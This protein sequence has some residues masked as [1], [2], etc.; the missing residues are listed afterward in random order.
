MDCG[1]VNTG[2]HD[3][4]TEDGSETR[5]KNEPR[6]GSRMPGLRGKR[7]AA[8]RRIGNAGP[9]KGTRAGGP[10]W[11]YAGPLHQHEQDCVVG[12]GGD[13]ADQGISG[14]GQTQT[15]RRSRTLLMI[16]LREREAGPDTSNRVALWLNANR[17]FPCSRANAR[18]GVLSHPPLV[19]ARRRA[20]LAITGQREGALTNS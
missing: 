14:E 12:C 15:S 10:C 2:P 4:H 17:A 9:A 7:E 8:V 11:R 13:S 6:K 16:A 20:N 18:A 3:G 5:D 19:S 1:R